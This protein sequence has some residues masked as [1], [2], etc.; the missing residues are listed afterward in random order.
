LAR[1]ESKEV[2]NELS[3][4]FKEKL[5]KKYPNTLSQNIIDILDD[6]ID[7]VVIGDGP[8]IDKSQNIIQKAG[9]NIMKWFKTL[10]GQTSASDLQDILEI[11]RR[12]NKKDGELMNEIVVESEEILTKMKNKQDFSENLRKCAQIFSSIKKNKYQRPIYFFE[13]WM[14]TL[15]SKLRPDEYTKLSGLLS[16]KSEEEITKVYNE[17][18]NEVM[19]EKKILDPIT[20]EYEAFKKANP[21]KIPFTKYT[22]KEG[23]LVNSGRFIF[24]PWRDVDWSGFRRFILIMDART[25]KQWRN[26]LIQRGIWSDLIVNAL[27]RYVNHVLLLPILYESIS[28]MFRGVISVTE[29]G[30]NVL[31]F[32][33]ANIIDFNED[34]KGITGAL[35]EEWIDKIREHFPDFENIITDLLGKTFS[36]KE[37]SLVDEVFSKTIAHIF[38]GGKKTWNEED[39]KEVKKWFDQFM[40]SKIK[41]YEDYKKTLTP[42]QRKIIED[43]ENKSSD[44]KQFIEDMI[45]KSE[46][47]KNTVVEYVDE[48]G[49][50]YKNLEELVK[51]RGK[52]YAFEAWCKKNKKVFDKEEYGIFYVKGESDGYEFKNG[53]FTNE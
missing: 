5:E 11:L 18:F 29:A 42:E 23:K 12:F 32:S 50:K 22:N 33:D 21:F 20:A 52:K 26:E 14:G 53:N 28:F 17:L 6:K 44:G 30:F 15:K 27:F 41:S 25:A 49:N 24:K 2:R 39:K 3:K 13:E 8:G 38:T 9:G 7:N 45:K 47:L 46:E 10:L 40:D 37:N 19:R 36:L 16:G 4:M 1:E 51:N 48:L 43:L 34:E 31:P 35:K